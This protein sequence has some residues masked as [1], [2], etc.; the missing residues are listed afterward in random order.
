[1]KNY[2]EYNG[3]SL[4]IT[5]ARAIEIEDKLGAGII[6]KMNTATD[7]LKDLS[8]VLAGAVEHGTYEER[9]AKALAIY[10]EMANEGK[11]IVDYQL[12]VFEVLVAA[13]FM[14]GEELKLKKAI[15]ENQKKILA[16]SAKKL[17]TL[18]TSSQ[19]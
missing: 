9:H 10:D 11:N 19:E 2:I 13:G 12:L 6:E 17:E 18:Q 7:Q 4:K 8:T 1:M 3:E 15:A 5:A 14:S 16:E